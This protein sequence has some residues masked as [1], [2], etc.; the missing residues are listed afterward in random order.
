MS[1]MTTD[2][3]R[4]P[5]A[6]RY[7]ARVRPSPWRLNVGTGGGV[8]QPIH[9]QVRTWMLVWPM[10]TLIA[11]QIVYFSGPARSAEA[12]QEVS[13]AGPRGSHVPLYIYL[14]FLFGFAALGH[15]KVLSALKRNTFLTLLLVLG[16]CSILWSFSPDT[17]FRMCVQVSACALFACYL[18]SSFT[19]E[20]FMQFLIFMGV[21]SAILSILF[22]IFLPDYGIFRG[23]GGN[24]WEGICGH[25]NSLGEN[26]AYLLT[27]VFFTAAYSMKRRIAYAALLLFLIVMSQSRGAWV[28][29]VALLGFVAW[30]AFIRRVRKHESR[31]VLLLTGA[32]T[33][34]A[35]GLIVN[36]WP[37]I[38]QIMGKSPTMSGRTGI[39]IEVMRSVIKKPILGY[40]L[41]G[42][43]FPGGLE[44]KRIALVLG[45]DNIGYA[46]SGFLEV[47]LQL[48]FLG[49]A[50]L[51]AMLVRA[52][53]QGVRLMR[54]S[55]YSPR[56]GW[57]LTILFLCAITNIDGGS[58]LS[59]DSL[60]WVLIMIACIRLNEEYQQASALGSVAR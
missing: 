51:T 46:E 32:V 9:Q 41:G 33:L 29:T 49:V 52:V 19:T 36:Y 37:F 17:T 27:P 58:F 40:A 34:I 4:S 42:F 43:W 50:L 25:K 8:E 57:S 54:S 28:D 20:R 35:L 2:I 5:W 23:Y 47:A 16:F 60:D 11:R 6:E 38:A 10:L 39:Y 21:L 45:W 12:Y 31:L 14:L 22:V 56:V 30:L 59:S 3:K 55:F 53:V 44:S 24:A 15:T 18:A 48:G 26:M 13:A 1:G 7:D